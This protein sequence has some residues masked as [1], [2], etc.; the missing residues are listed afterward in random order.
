MAQVRR[1][2]VLGGY[3]DDLREESRSRI[4]EVRSEDSLVPT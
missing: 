1:R 4:D 2:R 3:V